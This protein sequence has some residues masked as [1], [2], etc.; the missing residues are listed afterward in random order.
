MASKLNQLRRKL[1]AL[2]Q[3][4]L[5]LITTGQEYAVVGAYST[6]NLTL[7]E[8]EGAISKVRRQILSRKGLRI[9]RTYP[10]NNGSSSSLDY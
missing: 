1:A 8:I 10:N 9:R 5:D 3:A 4:E 7:K 2:E 6:K